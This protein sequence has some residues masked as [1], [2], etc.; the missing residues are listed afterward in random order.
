MHLQKGEVLV[1]ETGGGGGFGNPRERSCELVLEDLRE[2]YISYERAVVD[3]GLEPDSRE[4]AV[5]EPD[6]Q[7]RAAANRGRD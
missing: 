6:R 5:D 4:H 7:G 3:Y 1:L 2:G